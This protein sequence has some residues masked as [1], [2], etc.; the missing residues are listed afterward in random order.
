MT[1]R[2]CVYVNDKK[3]NNKLA[4]CLLRFMIKY[5]P[6]ATKLYLITSMFTQLIIITFFSPAATTSFQLAIVLS[7]WEKKELTFFFFYEHLM[8]LKGPLTTSIT[9]IYKRRNISHIIFL[10]HCVQPSATQVNHSRPAMLAS[11]PPTSFYPRLFIPY[12]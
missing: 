4:C 7:T 11:P 10:H 2:K 6:S 9:K 5:I 8:K 12:T 3:K 1:H